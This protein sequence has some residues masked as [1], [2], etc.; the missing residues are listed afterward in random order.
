MT[1]QPGALAPFSKLIAAAVSVAPSLVAQGVVTG[2]L[3]H[4]LVGAVGLVVAV[5]AVWK[6]PA[7]VTAHEQ[8]VRASLDELAYLRQTVE[9]LQ[10]AHGSASS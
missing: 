7:N 5:V 6:A 1:K 10:A 9:E 3:P 2:A 4:A 8:A